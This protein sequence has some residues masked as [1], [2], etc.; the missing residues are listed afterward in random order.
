MAHSLSLTIVLSLSLIALSVEAS[1]RRN[2]VDTGL[3][4]DIYQ[5]ITGSLS[6]PYE[7]LFAPEKSLITGRADNVEQR[8]NLT[9]EQRERLKE[10]RKRFQS[11]PPEERQ[12]LKEAR[13]KFKQLPLEER[14]RLKQKWRNLSPEER[15]KSIMRKKEKKG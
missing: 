1:V 6:N 3:S 14:K 8:K 9:S 12:R 13:K 2:P 15:H 4:I 11:L 5:P 10:R 7:V